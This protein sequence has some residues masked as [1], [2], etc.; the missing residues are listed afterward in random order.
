M[1]PA[2]GAH[3]AAH[4]NQLKSAVSA[5]KLHSTVAAA[6]SDVAAGVKAFLGKI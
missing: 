2:A 1:L 3:V 6:A 5:P 4:I